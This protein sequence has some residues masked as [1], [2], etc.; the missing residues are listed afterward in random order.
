[1]ISNPIPEILRSSLDNMCLQIKLLF[2]LSSY[3][4]AKK[5]GNKKIKYKGQILGLLN[6]CIQPPNERQIINSMNELN[7]IGA[8]DVNE[9]LTPLGFHL[10][11][12]SVGSVKIG[13]IL[14]YGCL[15]KCL[16]PCL[17]IASV[18]S[19][20]G[21]SIFNHI[22]SKMDEI[23]KIKRQWYN[24]NIDHKSDHICMYRAFK[25]WMTIKQ[26]YGAYK[27]NS[28]AYD[29]FLKR[30]TLE[31]IEG[32]IRQYINALTGIK[33]I[34]T[35]NTNRYDFID[36]ICGNNSVNSKFN[37]NLDKNMES[38]RII[39]SLLFAGLYPNLISIKKPVKKYEKTLH[40]VSEIENQSFQYKFYCKPKP[41]FNNNN[42]NNNNNTNDSGDTTYDNGRIFIHYTSCLFNETSY[43]L[44]WLTYLNKMK[45][46][47]LYAFDVTMLTVYGILLFGGK[48]EY[49][50]I[51][52]HIIIN[53]WSRFKAQAR[54][55]VIIKCLKSILD[56]YLLK[57]NANPS[58]NLSNSNII[59]IIEKLLKTDG[60]Q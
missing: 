21:K 20:D 4:Q 25:H 17:V 27:A 39:K 24:G 60:F 13:K 43:Q 7:T 51:N 1:M 30:N 48:I 8:F 18:L 49:D 32:V 46:K 55:A 31:Y 44:G 16:T 19:L 33:F 9:K 40:G 22:G 10:A 52:E 57:K 35:D 41:R 11:K 42:N 26:R 53:N 37:I 58:L 23:N 50:Y 12:L 29:N 28:F 36:S 45:T 34:N 38:N 47:K 5:T 54:I 15:F 2:M 6:D 59:N 56:Y 3:K 14:I